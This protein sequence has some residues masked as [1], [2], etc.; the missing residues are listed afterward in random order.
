MKRLPPE[1]CADMGT[2]RAQIDDLDR[3]LVARLAE[4]AR[5]IDRAAELKPGEGLPARID[6]RVEEVVARVRAEGVKDGL[7]AD[8]VEALWRPLIDWSIA[9]EER[10]LG[11]GDRP[12]EQG[13]NQ[14]QP[15][16]AVA[17]DGKEQIE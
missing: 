13:T 3:E 6:A 14:P 17:T 11:P 8:L 9:R 10:V 4:R 7:D 5:Y 1:A 2:L 15:G 12:R 16:L